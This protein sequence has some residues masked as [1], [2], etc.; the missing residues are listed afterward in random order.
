[1]TNVEQY[2]NQERRSRIVAAIQAAEKDT[3]GEIRVHVDNRCAGDPIKQALRCFK[4]MQMHKT[5]LSNGVLFYLALED[6]KFAILGD[7]GIDAVTPDDFWENIK[8]G[9][10]A[11]FQQGDIDGALCWG[12]QQAG[13]KLKMHF[14]CQASDVNELSDDISFES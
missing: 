14:P 7:K 5:A 3:S 11:M 13:E 4:K 8:Q 6:R 10:L 2:F 12:I 9:M 1:M